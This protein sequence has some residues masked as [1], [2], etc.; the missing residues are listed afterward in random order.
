MI[1]ILRWF[2][3][4]RPEVDVRTINVI[5]SEVCMRIVKL[6]VGVLPILFFCV[7]SYPTFSVEEST[8]HEATAK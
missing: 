6:S 4:F 7:F 5:F 8:A 3:L 2:W 1:Q